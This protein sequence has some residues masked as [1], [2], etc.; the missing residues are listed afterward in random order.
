MGIADDTPQK[1]YCI[2]AHRNKINGKV[3]IGISKNVKN[4][5]AGKEENYKHSSAIYNAF[6]KYGWDGF[7][8]IVMW[9]G[10]SGEDACKLEQALIFLFKFSKQSYNL[11][12]GGEGVLGGP[13]NEETKRKLRK[14]HLEGKFSCKRVYAFDLKTKQ[15]VK[16]YFS[17]VEAARDVNTAE[18]NISAAALGKYRYAAGY[19]WSYSP[20]INP[21]DAKYRNA[22]RRNTKEV[23]CYD[24]YGNYLKKYNSAQEAV[25]DVGGNMK[26]IHACCHKDK[27]TYMNYIWRYTLCDIEPEILNKVQFKRHETN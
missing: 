18:P 14:A 25:N 16:E 21:N 8:H 6:K 12:D 7:D 15:L 9:D 3:Y 22:G 4:R 17:T 11:G 10:L 23:Y 19:I 5:W 24:L 1:G 26:A 2:Y 27:V 13:M 20:T